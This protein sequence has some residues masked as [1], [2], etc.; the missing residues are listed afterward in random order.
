MSITVEEFRRLA[1]P[2]RHKYN[3]SAKEDRE[4]DGKIYDSRAE[5]ERA[6]HW[7]TMLESGSVQ[8][9]FEQVR[10]SLGIRE[11]IYVADFLIVAH[12]N[13]FAEDVKGTETPAFRK[14]K[15]LWQRYGRLPLCVV[16][17]DYKK[18]TFKTTEIISGPPC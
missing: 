13:V 15:K 4:F 8:A 14:V 7:R 6:K 1:K 2:K 5:M 17:Y 9:V 3:V 18:R 16:K 11:N 10:M 12:G